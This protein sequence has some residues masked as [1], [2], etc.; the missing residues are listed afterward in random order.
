MQSNGLLDALPLWGLFIA[1]LLVVLVSVEC[2]YRLGNID[3]AGTSRRNRHQS[4][5]WLELRLV[6]APSFSRS[7]LVWQPHGLTPEGKCCSTRP[8][9]LARPTCAQASFRSGQRRFEYSCETMWTLVWKLSGRTTLRREYADRKAF[10]TNS[11]VTRRPSAKKIP[12]RL[13]SVYSFSHSMRSSTSTR[14][15]YKRP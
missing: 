3:A 15:E 7:P 11:G 9:R 12:I 4:A 8:T 6:C 5:P 1:I 10:N 14:N 13:W 2:G